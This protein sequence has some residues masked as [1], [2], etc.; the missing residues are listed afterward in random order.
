MSLEIAY[1][2]SKRNF[3]IEDFLTTSKFV[4]TYVNDNVLFVHKSHKMYLFL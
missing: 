4:E 3:S 2:I 1:F